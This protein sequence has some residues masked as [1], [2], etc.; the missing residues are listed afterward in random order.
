MKRKLPAIFDLTGYCVATLLLLLGFAFP[1]LAQNKQK[2]D[3]VYKLNGE[4]LKG[5]VKAMEDHTITFVYTGET[6][7][8]TL[9]KEEIAKI[10]FSSGRTEVISSPKAETAGSSNVV[11][12]AVTADHTGK[13]AILPF[14]FVTDG[15]PASDDMGLKVQNE[16]FA[17]FNNH[18]G[19]SKISDNRQTNALL[20]KAG[21]NAQNIMGY[22][23][24][25]LCGILGVEYI[26]TGMVTVDK[27][28]Q[29]T[30]NSTVQ[31]TS[32]ER[33]NETKKN[34]SNTSSYGSSYGTNEQ[35]YATT[36]QLSIYNDKGDNIFNQDRK[37]FW[38]QQDAYKATLE[39]LVK[40]CPLYK[41]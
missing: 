39:Y 38:H 4:E 20:V 21:I 2:V 25:E 13:V 34:S 28:T 36:L 30:Y 33:K 14:G 5:E 12:A 31:N 32:S 37:S 19:N 10:V 8:Y 27:T 29:T 23:M 18:A 6:L 9:K 26:I 40:R 11:P 16:C 15:Q 3:I 7:Q 35:N 22:T 1:A 41:K 17:L 24:D